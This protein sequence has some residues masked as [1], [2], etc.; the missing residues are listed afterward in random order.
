MLSPWLPLL[1]C[2]LAVH[3]LAPGPLRDDRVKTAVFSKVSNGMFG[4]V[5]DIRG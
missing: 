5:L 3:G 2:V 4:Y 1:S